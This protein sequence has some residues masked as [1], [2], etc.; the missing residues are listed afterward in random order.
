MT[1]NTVLETLGRISKHFFPI[2]MQLCKYNIFWAYCNSRN[3]NI[4]AWKLVIINDSLLTSLLCY[5]S[6]ET[7]RTFTCNCDEDTDE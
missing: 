3:D 2:E 1:W 5:H 6:D 4:R 7:L